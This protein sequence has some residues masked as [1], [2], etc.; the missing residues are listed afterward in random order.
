MTSVRLRRLQSDYE[1][2]RALAHRHP[3]IAIEAVSGNPPDRYRLLLRVDSLR[4][5]GARV[6]RAGEHRLEIVLPQ[7]YPRDAPLCRMLTPVFHPNIAPHAVCI[8]DHWSAAESLDFMIQRVGEMLAFQSYNIKSPLNGRA[9][10][11]VAQ[12]LEE[13]PIEKREFFIDVAAPAKAPAEAPGAAPGAALAAACAGCGGPGPFD[14][15][16]DGHALCA[17][18]LAR[19]PTCSRILCIRCGATI[20]QVCASAQRGNSP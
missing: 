11:W 8:G 16:G 13:L 4:E 14:L 12:H 6:E 19:C 3:R 2:V 7:G 20:C 18:C 5:R 17:D 1:A 15:C 10:Q 9:A